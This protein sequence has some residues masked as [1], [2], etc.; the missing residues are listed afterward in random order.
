MI[1]TNIDE[2]IIYK[3]Y[4]VIIESCDSCTNDFDIK[5]SGISITTCRDCIIKNLI[6]VDCN[7]KPR[8]STLCDNIKCKKCFYNSFASVDKCAYYYDE[9]FKTYEIQIPRTITKY[10]LKKL[11]FLCECN[12]IFE[13]D[14]NG[15]SK[16]HWCKVCCKGS[17]TLCKYLECKS[18]ENRSFKSNDKCKYLI[19]NVNPRFILKASKIFLNFKCEDCNHL[20]TQKISEINSDK[21]CKYCNSFY[22]CEDLNCNFCFNKSFASNEKSKYLVDDVNPRFLTKKC[23]DK[24]NFKCNVCNHIFNK[25]ISN[26]SDN[27]WCEFCEGRVCGNKDCK[28]CYIRTFASVE[29]SKYVVDKSINLYKI[30]KTSDIHL[31]FIC[32]YNHKFNCRIGHITNGVWCNVCKNKTERKLLDYLTN[33]FKNYNITFQPKFDWC[34]NIKTNNYLPFDFLITVSEKIKILIELDGRQHFIKINSWDNNVDD[35]QERDIYKMK[36]AINNNYIFIRINQEDIW[37][38]NINLEI[39]KNLI[40]NISKKEFYKNKNIKRIENIYFISKNLNIYD[41]H[42]KIF[43]V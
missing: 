10:S 18:C 21:W 9:H 23:H 24:Y 11:K 6:E 29:K 7:I 2:N 32:E 15:V 1:K 22:F 4:T 16:N 34:K 19:D 5:E 38:N 12:H 40:I 36:L 31:D 8:S 20:L 37:C 28:N 41:N 30:N 43:S 17:S 35:I 3:R 25:R 33:E 26:V 14:I 27:T 39:I 13:K 42:I